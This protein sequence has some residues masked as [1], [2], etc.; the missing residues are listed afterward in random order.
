MKG[1]KRDFDCLG[2]RDTGVLIMTCM[3][4]NWKAT[5]HWGL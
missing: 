4:K 5:S 3:G 2:E 1:F